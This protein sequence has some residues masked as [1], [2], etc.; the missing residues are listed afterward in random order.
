MIFRACTFAALGIAL[1]S[2]GA[3]GQATG[4]INRIIVDG[5]GRPVAD[6]RLELRPGS[7]HVASEEDGHFAFRGVALGKYSIVARRIGYQ[8][9]TTQVEVTQSGAKPVIVLVAIPRVLDSVRIVERAAVN[10]Y[11]AI[12]LDDAGAPVPDASV[13]VEG[14][15][16]T[17]RTDSLGRF[18]VPKQVHGTLVIRM[19]KMGYRAYLGSF[20]MIATRA[21]TLRMSRL[22][23]GLSPVEITEASGFGR[24]TFV[25]QDLDQRSRWKTQQAAIISREE[26]SAMGRLNICTALSFTPTGARY[27]VA[28]ARSCVILNGVGMTLM[29]ASAYYADQIEM[30]EYYPRNS[31]WS[32]NLMARGC[33]G[34]TLVIWMRKDPATKP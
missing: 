33:G 25:Y 2:A 10:R 13:T 19:R 32:H 24:D 4:D 23:Q 1:S 21:D 29:P 18:V 20:R 27:H 31:D 15:S 14:I 16:N 26:L 8:V 6:A 22:A 17:L 5:N 12:V 9:L 7:L 30:V 28:C 3:R 11:S 34:T